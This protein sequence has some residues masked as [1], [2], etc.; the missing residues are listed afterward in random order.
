MCGLFCGLCCS[1]ASRVA[2]FV[3]EVDLQKV[4]WSSRQICPWTASL[5][6]TEWTVLW[7]YLL[8]HFSN[9]VHYEGIYALIVVDSWKDFLYLSIKETSIVLCSILAYM[10]VLL[11]KSTKSFISTSKTSLRWL[12]PHSKQNTV[13]KMQRVTR[14]FSFLRNYRLFLNNGRKLKMRWNPN[15]NPGQRAIWQHRTRML[16]ITVCTTLIA[17]KIGPDIY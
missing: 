11:S 7:C 3:A 1:D 13:F 2:Q 6:I 14:I 12:T 5:S 16:L 17:A 8:E 10:H 9:N 4:R 15:T